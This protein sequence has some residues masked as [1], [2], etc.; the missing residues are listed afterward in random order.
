MSN[1]LF[2]FSKYKFYQQG[3]GVQIP[4]HF[5][6]RLLCVCVRG[7]KFIPLYMLYM[8]YMDLPLVT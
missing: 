7:D 1:F 3:M 4:H 8:L 2:K 5:S 6:K